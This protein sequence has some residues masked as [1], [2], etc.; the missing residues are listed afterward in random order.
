[1]TFRIHP[2]ATASTP[3]L[4]KFCIPRQSGLINALS[5]IEAL[6]GDVDLFHKRCEGLEHFSH[7]W[8]IFI[9][10]KSQLDAEGE[11]SLSHVKPPRLGGK[12]RMGVWSTRSPHRPNSL[13]MSLVKLMRIEK[14]RLWVLGLDV[15]CGTPIV[16][17]KPYIPEYDHVQVEK[18]GWQAPL[19]SLRLNAQFNPVPGANNILLSLTAEQKTVLREILSIDPRP[20]FHRLDGK[21]DQ[22]YSVYLNVLGLNVNVHFKV[23]QMEKTINIFSVEHYDPS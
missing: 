1:M 20:A 4:E 12:K 11:Q 23:D 8:V 18:N 7:L 19:E 3:Y 17:L 5:S 14:H 9:F 16:D 13:G 10:H 6:P 15:L 21:S 2:I 22:E